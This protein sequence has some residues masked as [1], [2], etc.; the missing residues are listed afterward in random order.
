MTVSYDIS[1]IVACLDAAPSIGATLDSIATAGSSFKEGNLE[2]IVVDGG[3]KDGTLQQ[4]A[5]LQT[6]LPN[7]KV[8]HQ[9]SRGIAAARNLGIQAAKAPY[10]AFCDADDTWTTDAI[11]LRMQALCRES[12]AWAATGQVYF[13]DAQGNR[14]AS[15]VRRT[16]GTTHAGYTPG[17]LLIRSDVF[18][19]IG[20]FDEDL[21]VG[22]DSDWILRAQQAFGLPIILPQIVLNKG[23]RAGSLSTDVR[24]YRKEMLLIARRFL[25]RARRNHMP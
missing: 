19:S 14:K 11:C 12:K 5:S 16:T 22:A 21:S 13:C 10:I 15:P 8:I 6:A 24:T 23:I 9:K 25:N 4:I 20:L 18:Q 1:V 2:L 7:C 3:S 17:A